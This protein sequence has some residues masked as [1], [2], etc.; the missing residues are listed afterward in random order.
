LHHYNI[1]HQ[2]HSLKVLR[3]ELKLISATGQLK[4]FGFPQGY[5]EHLCSAATLPDNCVP[6]EKEMTA[7]QADPRGTTGTVLMRCTQAADGQ[8]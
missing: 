8:Q 1:K 4:S 3:W 7:P 6:R 5:Q 2:D